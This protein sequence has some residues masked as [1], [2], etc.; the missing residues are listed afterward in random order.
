MGGRWRAFL[1]FSLHVQGP[2]GGGG[3]PGTPIMPSPGG[4]GAW[5][6]P[7]E[8]C[9]CGEAPLLSGPHASFPPDST[10]S[11]ENMYTIM[12]PIGPA[13]GRANVSGEL[14]IGGCWRQWPSW[15]D[16]GPSPTPPLSLQF[17]LGPSSEGPIAAMS[18][19]EPHHVNGSLGEWAARD[20][21]TPCRR[22]LHDPR[23]PPGG[24]PLPLHLCSSLAFGS[25]PEPP[26]GWFS[27]TGCA[28]G[29]SNN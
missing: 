20:G 8:G 16:G 22:L 17:P 27:D 21:P 3:P 29:G 15:C 7:G 14:Q 10:N 5:V 18:A 6:V 26:H 28:G 25:A 11:S 1:T 13:A 4:T 12:N 9:A 23:A 24:L 2:P 19:L